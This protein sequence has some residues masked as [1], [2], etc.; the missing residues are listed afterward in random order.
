M[1]RA[2]VYARVGGLGL[3]PPLEL[4]ILQKFYYLR[5]GD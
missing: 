3:T 4:H 1:S 5:K 2:G